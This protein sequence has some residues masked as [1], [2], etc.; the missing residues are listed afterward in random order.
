MEGDVSVGL[1]DDVAGLASGFG[2]HDT[3]HTLDLAGEGLLG[4]EGVE[5]QLSLLKLHGHLCLLDGMLDCRGC[6]C[7]NCGCLVQDTEAALAHLYS[8]GAEGLSPDAGRLPEAAARS[9]CQQEGK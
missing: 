8:D 7:P 6:G 2:A 9:L 5:G 1:D 3:L 4:A